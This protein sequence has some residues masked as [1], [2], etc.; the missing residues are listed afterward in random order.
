MLREINNTNTTARDE[1]TNNKHPGGTPARANIHWHALLLPF[2]CLASFIST[3]WWQDTRTEAC[4]YVQILHRQAS[5]THN[6]YTGGNTCSQYQRLPLLTNCQYFRLTSKQLF[7]FHVADSRKVMH[8]YLGRWLSC[9]Q[10]FQSQLV[11]ARLDWRERNVMTVQWWWQRFVPT[12]FITRVHA[13]L[14]LS[15][16]QSVCSPQCS[17]KGF[18]K[19]RPPH[20]NTRACQPVMSSTTITWQMYTTTSPAIINT[21]TVNTFMSGPDSTQLT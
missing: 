20:H 1:E 9:R 15:T 13:C 17:N 21:A 16:H 18:H 8:Y 6:R 2:V 10:S 19:H 4:L 5:H 3:Y 12:P 14:P 7:Q 11:S